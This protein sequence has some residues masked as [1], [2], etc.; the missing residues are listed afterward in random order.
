ME[1][2]TLDEALE[3]VGEYSKPERFADIRRHLDPAWIERALEATGTAPPPR[4]CPVG[5]GLLREVAFRSRL[6]GIARL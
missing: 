1:K 2:V 5:P 6:K 3:W 4:T